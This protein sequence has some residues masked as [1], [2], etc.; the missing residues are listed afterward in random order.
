M[1]ETTQKPRTIKAMPYEVEQHTDPGEPYDF[2]YME[3]R[4][5]LVDVDTG[6]IVDDAQG[7]GYKSAAGAH[8]AYGYKTAKPNVKKRRESA[9]R[10]VASFTRKHRA[11]EDELDGMMFY[12]AKDGVEVTV[13]DV[14]R[15]LSDSGIDVDALGFTIEEYLRYR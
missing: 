11:I 6:E 3:T 2:T 13:E 9:K 5:R 1:S 10:K 7:Y 8:R 15:L 4:W 14:R 12:A